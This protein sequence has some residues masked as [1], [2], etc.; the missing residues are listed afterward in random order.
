MRR[1][2]LA[3]R[4]RP[5]PAIAFTAFARETDRRMALEAGYQQHLAKP[6]GDDLTRIGGLIRSARGRRGFTQAELAERLQISPTTVRAAE[7]G[8]PK[9]AVGILISLLWILGIGP[10]GKALSGQ[11][12]QPQ[13]SGPRR[14]VRARKSLDDF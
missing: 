12:E 9:V 14:R 13:T 2:E 1:Q 10:I 3:A 5:I 4:R 7:Q 8:D 6:V 11:A